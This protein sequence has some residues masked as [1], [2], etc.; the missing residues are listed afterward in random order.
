M[1]PTRRL[2]VVSQLDFGEVL[3]GPAARQFE[4]VRGGLDAGVQVDLVGRSCTRSLPAGVSFLPL[5][6]FQLTDVQPTD[7][8]VVSAYLPGRWIMDLGS[9]G[10]PFH[11]DLYCITATEILPGLDAMPGWKAWLQRWRRILRYATLCA[12]AETVYVSTPLQTTLLA[13][14]FLALPGRTAQR[15]A[16]QLPSKVR[17]APMS[18]PDRP[19][20]AAV[21]NPYPAA[22]AGRPIF[23]WGGGIWKWFDVETVLRAFDILQ[24]RGS[25][26]VLFFLAGRN[27]SGHSDQDVP[28]HRAEE[29]ARSLGLLGNAVHFNA[30][31][32]GPQQLPGYL[33]HCH[34]GILGNHPHL[35]SAASWRTRQLDLLWAGR[36]AIVAGDDPL[37]SRMA[38]AGAA[39]LV[40]PGDPESLARAIE[41]SLDPQEHRRRC[42]AS[43]ELARTLRRGSVAGPIA[44]ALSSPGGFTGI[45]TRAPWAW[46]ARYHLGV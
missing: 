9:S 5:D 26:A 34:G 6:A 39:W 11:A 18:V 14:M 17:V 31:R 25:P 43:R 10:V 12:R 1:N 28:H 42:D 41:S 13:G 27:P 20:P 4:L 30:A 8:L 19:F 44:D 32:V 46:K 22:L 29:L 3:L 45:G 7:A 23:L 16:F 38:E 36:P 24:R 21:A 40:P 2:L 35:E 37:S 15:L 33:Q